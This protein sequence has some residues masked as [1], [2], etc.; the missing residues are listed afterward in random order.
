MGIVAAL[1]L[2]A[3]AP[4]QT[5]PVPVLHSPGRVRATATVSATIVPAVRI[6]LG[7]SGAAPIVLEG[8]EPRIHNSRRADGRRVL[9]E[10]H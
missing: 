9:V 10:F 7:G 2:A 5:A 4:S 8:R 3:S 6:R 1:I